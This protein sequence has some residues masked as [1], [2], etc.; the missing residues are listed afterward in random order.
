MGY[1]SL[2]EGMLNIPLFEG[3]FY[4]SQVVQDFFHRQYPLEFFGA[5]I[6][7]YLGDILPYQL[8]F[9]KGFWSL[10]KMT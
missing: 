7:G 5:G 2:P 4:T 3:F 9:L 10:N 8:V 6:S 1:V